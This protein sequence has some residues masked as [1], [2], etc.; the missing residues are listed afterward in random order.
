MS[1]H[2][3][4]RY[5]PWAQPG[6]ESWDD[7]SPEVEFCQF[8]GWLQ[9]MLNPTV[10]IETGVGV[11][12]IT[13]E[14]DTTV[15]TYLG[16]EADPEWR[17]NPDI[18][19]QLAVTPTVEEYAAADL[20]FLDSDPLFRIPEIASWARSGKS[21]SVA[22]VHDAGNH[23]PTDPQLVHNRVRTAITATTIHGIWLRNPRGGW[24]GAHP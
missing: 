18:E 15:C 20:L 14:L 17:R 1:L 8:C 4:T 5:T 12:R 21:G 24:M 23:H 2:D 9:R 19:Y 10:I 11:G 3:E 6:W 13:A 22:V 7:W 16:F